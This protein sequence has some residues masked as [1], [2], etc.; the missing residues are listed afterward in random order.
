M[1]KSRCTVLVQK[2]LKYIKIVQFK[3]QIEFGRGRNNI[4]SILSF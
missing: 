4:N 3:N 2:R 1:E